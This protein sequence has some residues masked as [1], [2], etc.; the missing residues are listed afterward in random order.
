M[1]RDR[2]EKPEVAVPWLGQLSVQSAGC[3]GSSRSKRPSA[4]GGH[5]QD[6]ARRRRSCRAT[7]SELRGDVGSTS[8][9]QRWG[10]D[11]PMRAP[12]PQVPDRWRGR[13]AGRRAPVVGQ[14]GH[15]LD[16]QLRR[17]DAKQLVSDGLAL[18]AHHAEN[19]CI[20]SYRDREVIA[21]ASDFSIPATNA[22][23]LARSSTAGAPCAAY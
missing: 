7:D 14:P 9:T 19:R 10:A 3:T 2:F 16:V 13:S 18:P 5:R 15:H 12:Q 21:L 20:T 8:T 22:L 23:K 11:Q 1:S 4:N 17:L 6:A